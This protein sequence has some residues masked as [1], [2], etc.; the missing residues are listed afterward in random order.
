LEYYHKAIALYKEAKFAQALE[1]FKDI[2]NWEDKTNK[3]IYNIYIQR[4]EH[5]I[6]QPP[7]N[8]NGVFVH[9]TKG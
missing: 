8:F 3:N 7:E 6:E 4:C 5:Y 2:Q 1:I 9:T